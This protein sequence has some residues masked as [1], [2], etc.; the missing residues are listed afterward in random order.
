MAMKGGGKYNFGLS[1][2]W[3]NFGLNRKKGGTHEDEKNIVLLGCHI[4]R[5]DFIYVG[6][7]RL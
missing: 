1:K 4:G 5:P 3:K 6:S 7:C 2:Q